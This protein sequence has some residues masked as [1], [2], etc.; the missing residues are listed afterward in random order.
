MLERLHDGRVSGALALL[1]LASFAY[2]A[3]GL[4]GGEWAAFDSL[5]IGATRR[6]DSR[7]LDFVMPLVTRAGEVATVSVVVIVG[8]AW[9]WRAGALRA[10][11]AVFGAGVLTGILTTQLQSHFARLR[12]HAPTR[13]AAIHDY[14]FPSG[15]AMAGTAVYGTVAV[16]LARQRPRWRG[17]L[18]VAGPTLAFLLGFSRVYLGVHWPSDVVAGWLMGLAVLMASL[19]IQGRGAG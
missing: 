16:V 9:A 2:I 18:S 5:V 19:V 13:I 17:V 7:F 6:L 1:A 15:H 4:P 14:G 8:S 12:P 3:R 10:A 11:A